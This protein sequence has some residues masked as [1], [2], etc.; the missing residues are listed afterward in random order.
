MERRGGLFVN[1][2]DAVQGDSGGPML[3]WR[4]GQPR[5]AA[6]NVAVIIDAGDLGVAVGVSAFKATAA[7][8]G[9]GT[10]G[11]PGSVSKPLDGVVKAKAEGR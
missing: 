9:A 11:K 8:L 2:C 10:A 5:V 3:I 1:D 4:D 6:L 7:K